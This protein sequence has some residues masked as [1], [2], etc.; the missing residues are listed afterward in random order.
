V[1]TYHRYVTLHQVND[2]LALGWL[3]RN[4]LA[5][6]LHGKYAVHMVWLCACKVVEPK[7]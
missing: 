2:Y 6:C 1:I 7:R 4:S 3:A 5:G